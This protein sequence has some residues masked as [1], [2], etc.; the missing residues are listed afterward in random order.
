M[1]ILSSVI[2]TEIF[3]IADGVNISDVCYSTDVRQYK[4][5]FEN[6]VSLLIINGY[7]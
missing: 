2:L 3:V 7:Q 4:Y 5:S 6:L 1:F